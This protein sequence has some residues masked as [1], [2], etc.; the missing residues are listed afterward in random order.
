[1]DDRYHCL[2]LAPAPS[3]DRRPRARAPNASKKNAL[4]VH[5]HAAHTAHATHS[6]H[7]AHATHTSHATA[8]VVGVVVIVLLVLDGD[9]GDER[10]GGQKQAGDAGTV[11][12]E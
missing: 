12:Q 7:P 9:V 4:H 10:F 1:M 3:A 6:S 2:R 8:V 5:P 11:L